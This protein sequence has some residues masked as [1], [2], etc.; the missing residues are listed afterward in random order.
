MCGPI[1]RTVSGTLMCAAVMTVDE[2]RP[3]Q[4]FR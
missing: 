1:F 2:V 3:L 4:L